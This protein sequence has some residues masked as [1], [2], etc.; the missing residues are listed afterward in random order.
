MV[1][2]A[3]R[4]DL[5]FSTSQETLSQISPE[6]C[7]RSSKTL[8]SGDNQYLQSQGQGDG[9]VNREELSLDYQYP[10]KPAYNPNTGEV[11]T[12]GSPELTS[13]LS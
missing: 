3:F 5:P 2:I 6:V 12:G 1:L 10:Y 7:L 4:T 13:Q 11:E 9:T 8:P